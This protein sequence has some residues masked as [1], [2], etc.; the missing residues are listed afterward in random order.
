MQLRLTPILRRPMTLLLL[1]LLPLL[2]LRLLLLLPLLL[3]LQHFLLML[4]LVRLPLRLL[5]LRLPRT[6]LLRML[7]PLQLLPVPP[8]TATLQMPQRLLLLLLMMPLKLLR[9]EALAQGIQLF[10]FRDPA[11]SRLPEFTAGATR[12]AGSAVTPP[13]TMNAITSALSAA[14][15]RTAVVGKIN[16]WPA[17]L[18]DCGR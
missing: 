18:Y 6:T 13:D 16:S 11:G 9:S 5:L 2:L 12:A 14:S 17:K 3:V 4:V 10:E 7:L 8:P 1:L 15:G